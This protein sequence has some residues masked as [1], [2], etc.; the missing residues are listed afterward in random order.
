MKIISCSNKMLRYVRVHV[1]L[2]CRV[3]NTSSI[4]FVSLGNSIICRCQSPAV[5]SV[6]NASSDFSHSETVYSHTV[7]KIQVFAF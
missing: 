4:P 3:E 1:R 6:T 2:P 7:G 5:A